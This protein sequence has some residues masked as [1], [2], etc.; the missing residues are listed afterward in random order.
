MRRSPFFPREEALGAVFFDARGWETA[1]EDLW[2][3]STHVA[4]RRF[5]PT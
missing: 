1:G 2:D 3:V 4:T 5:T